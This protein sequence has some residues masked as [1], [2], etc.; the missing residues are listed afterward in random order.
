MLLVH[1]HAVHHLVVLLLR[2]ES[3]LL[4]SLELA[5]ELLDEVLLLSVH[6]LHDSFR[7]LHVD[8][9]SCFAGRH[10]FVQE[11]IQFDWLLQRLLLFLAHA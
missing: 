9:V 2:V 4:L 7:F 8:E 5:Q 6:A 3:G 11:R 1:E 10:D